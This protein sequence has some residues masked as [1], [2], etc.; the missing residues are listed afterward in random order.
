MLKVSRAAGTISNYFKLINTMKEWK[1][2]LTF[3][4]ITLDYVQRLHN[5]EL[6]IGN[7]LSTIYKKHANFKFLIGI[8]VDKEILEKNPY[9]KFEICHNNF[10]HKQSFY[11]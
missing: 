1:P 6:K 9:E 2:T 3:D 4:E 7:Q 10:F 8:A 11:K 5:Y